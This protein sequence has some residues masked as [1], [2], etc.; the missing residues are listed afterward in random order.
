MR[1]VSHDLCYRIQSAQQLEILGGKAYQEAEAYVAKLD[2]G[3]HHRPDLTASQL[4][5]SWS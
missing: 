4:G 5:W 1:A 2:G 3:L